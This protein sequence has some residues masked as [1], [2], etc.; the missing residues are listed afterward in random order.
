ME[1][2]NEP[3]EP[4]PGPIE[5]RPAE[6]GFAL[7]RDNV[8]LTDLLSRASEAWSRD[9]A[10]WLLAMLL[11]G[12]LALG[13]P[14]ALGLAWAF[15]TAIQP[16]SGEASAAFAAVN[17]IVRFAMYLVQ[18][19][20]SAVFT[21]G[22]WAMAIRGIRGQRT[23]VGVLFSQL[24]KI[25]KYILQSL[26]AGLGVVL[27]VLPIIVIIFLMFVGPID[28]DTPMSEIVDDAG[29]P[30]AIAFLVLLP[31]Y[32][33]IATGIAFMQAELAFNDDAGPIDAIVYSWRIARGKR[34]R[35]IGVGLLAILIATGS[36]MLCGIGLL[37]GAPLSMLLFCALFLALRNGADV[38]RANTGTILGRKY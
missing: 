9:L 2:P 36:A 15:F 26:A 13:I 32:I 24:S 35:I 28:L 18:L 33:Y 10:S 29:M 23:T 30:F 25:W 12:L 5:S 3:L 7:T 20:L 8:T 4:E 19:V 34:W 14:F 31:L 1:P 6:L 17:I 16:S 37:F 22:L 21:L 27:I 11:Y 38:P